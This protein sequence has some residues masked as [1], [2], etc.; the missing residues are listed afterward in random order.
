MVERSSLGKLLVVIAALILVLAGNVF[1]ILMGF[2]IVL[3]TALYIDRSAFRK[4]G[5]P[6]FWLFSLSVVLLAGLLLGKNPRPVFGIDIS[7]DGLFAGLMMN[8]R[9]FSLVLG[10][11]L[12]SRS[13]T[14]ARF[15]SLTTRLGLPHYIPAFQTALETLPR[16]KSAFKDSRQKGR[17]FGFDNLVDF[18][19]LT[20]EL[21]SRGCGIPERVMIFGITGKRKA[22]KTSLMRKIGQSASVEGIPVGGFIQERYSNDEHFSCGFNVVSVAN[23]NTQMIAEKQGNAPFSFSEEAFINAA[24]WLRRDAEG[25]QLLLVDEMGILEARGEGHAEGVI[26]TMI[27]HPDK[28]WILSL[29]KDILDELMHSFGIKQERIINLDKENADRKGFVDAVLSALREISV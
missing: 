10:M 22:G 19:L 21:A 25:C 16:M 4:L 20:G 14:R 29:R 6:R 26:S 18:I 11:V 28:V 2:L 1:A 9:A 17:L 3:T 12:I 13:L 24:S 7:P 5:K 23:G 8:V 15:L 27:K